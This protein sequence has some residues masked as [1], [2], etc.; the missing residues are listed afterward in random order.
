LINPI[1]KPVFFGCEDGLVVV[2]V[3]ELS[4]DVAPSVVEEGVDVATGLVAPIEI[5]APANAEEGVV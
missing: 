1:I 5:F 2:A 4:D 3:E